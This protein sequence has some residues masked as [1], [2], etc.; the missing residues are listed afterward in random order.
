M[1]RCERSSRGQLIWKSTKGCGGGETCRD[2]DCVPKETPG[3]TSVK[4]KIMSMYIKNN[5]MTLHLEVGDK[6]K[7]LAPGQLGVVLEGSSDKA[8]PNGKIKI[9]KVIGRFAIA[10]TALKDLGDNRWVKIDV[11]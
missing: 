4:V 8:L 11:R 3:P 10:S 2:G 9:L 5:R 1:Q 6:A 7:D